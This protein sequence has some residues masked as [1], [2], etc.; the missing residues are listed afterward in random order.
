MSSDNE[1]IVRR[2]F[3]DFCSDGRSELA[4][5]H[6]SADYASH[7]PQAPPAQ[8]PD[9]VIEWVGLYQESLDGH[10]HVDEMFSAGDR[11]VTRWTG[12]ARRSVI[13]WGSRRR[14]VR[15]A[16]RRSRSTA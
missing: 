14:V 1:A 13:S 6:V 11:V 2:F 16:S 9:G 5:E 10:W 7:G 3:D 12:A 15:S 8:G 4:G